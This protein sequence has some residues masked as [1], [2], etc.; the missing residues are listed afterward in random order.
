MKIFNKKAKFDYEL[1]G[2]GVE[3]GISLLGIE[4]KSLGE[5]RGDLSNSF[6]KIIGNEAF[7]VNANFPAVGIKGYDPLRSR[8]L[9]LHKS[10]LLA[11]S[12]KIKQQNLQ[13]VPLSIYNKKSHNGSEGR[14]IKLYLELGKGKKKFDKKAGKKV[15][16]INRDIEREFRVKD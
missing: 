9:L 1:T 15:Q 3:A 4:A 12:T 16:D 11:L 2:E 10:Q 8:K 13:L 14:L 7:L 5:G 6:V